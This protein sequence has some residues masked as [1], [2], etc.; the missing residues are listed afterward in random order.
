MLRPYN[1][2]DRLSCWPRVRS[3]L[4]LGK[5]P[6]P[7][8]FLHLVLIATRDNQ[9]GFAFRRMGHEQIA[10]PRGLGPFDRDEDVHYTVARLSCTG[11]AAVFFGELSQRSF[12]LPAPQDGA[13]E[14]SIFG[15]TGDPFGVATRIDVQAVAGDQVADFF[16]LL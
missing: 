5:K 4:A 12:A 8:Y 14:H 13:V 16:F 3:D 6:F 7:A 1:L 11:P 9:F 2:S 10:F 15:E